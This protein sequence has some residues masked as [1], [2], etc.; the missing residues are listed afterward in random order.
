MC[1]LAWRAA[2][3]PGGALTR[4]WWLPLHLACRILD[5]A[6]V[7]FN[8]Y[9]LPILLAKNDVRNPRD[10]DFHVVFIY[11]GYLWVGICPGWTVFEQQCLA[12]LPGPRCV[13]T[14]RCVFRKRIAIRFTDLEVNPQRTDDFPMD[15]GDAGVGCRGQSNHD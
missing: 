14:D 13:D 4:I 1:R 3:L 2:S 10:R 5:G 6:N 11:R 8:G 15:L 7:V 9:P 12:R